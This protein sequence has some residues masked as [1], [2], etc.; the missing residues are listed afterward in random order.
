MKNG[1]EKEIK[2]LKLFKRQPG[3][4]FGKEKEKHGDYQNG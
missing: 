1:L 4:G 2:W 3:N